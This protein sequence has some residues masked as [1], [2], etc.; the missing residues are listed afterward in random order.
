M[1][2]FPLLM[3]PM[4]M[5]G[6]ASIEKNIIEKEKLK[7]IRVAYID[8]NQTPELLDEF[9]NHNKFKI[10]FNIESDA[11]E[12]MLESDSIDIAIIVDKDFK[13]KIQS[14]SV[15][16][17]KLLYKTSDDLKIANK[18]ATDILEW[19]S[20]K[21]LTKRLIDL[22]ID[23]NIFNPFD[24]K[25]TDIASSREK[26]AKT[27]GGILP[28]IFMIFCF[29]GTTYPGIDL[30]AGEKERGTLETLLVAPATYH[31]I[32]IGKFGVICLSG[33]LSAL[34]SLLSIGVG[35]YGIQ[36]TENIPQEIL[37][38]ASDILQFKTILLLLSLLLPT[39]MFFSSL[40]LSLSI[41][42]KSFKE[43]QSLIQPLSIAVIFPV[44]IG[45]IIP[46][47]TLNYSTAMIPI[48]N[49]ALSSKEVIAGT[50]N[51]LLLLEVYL[52]AFLTAM[53]GIYI[54]SY[55]FKKESIIFR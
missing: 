23:K 38:F 4:L 44:A 31:E 26:L 24:V 5:L 13:E 52:S 27:I 51:P 46:G 37:A 43:A 39:T 49:I 16:S 33:L 11:I 53:I 6:I 7:D 28:Y 42:A 29:M 20:E 9:N 14:M 3:F 45:S 30:G 8:Y 22:N 12:S 41:Y 25:E 17:I 54:C 15:P 18:K 48:L 47:I 2:I 55:L 34:V 21:I 32:L 36:I 1:L 19:Y 50:I 10:I 35:V 40:V